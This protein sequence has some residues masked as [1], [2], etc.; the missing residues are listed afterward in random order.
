MLFIPYKHSARFTTVKTRLPGKGMMT[1]WETP[2]G[3]PHI[4]DVAG[5]RD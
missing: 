3:T 1:D 2:G 5:S 4:Q